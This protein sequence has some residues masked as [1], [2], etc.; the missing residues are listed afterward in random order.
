MKTTG[1]TKYL[2]VHIV[3]SKSFKIS[4]HQ[5]RRSFYR[6]ARQNCFW[7]GGFTSD[8]NQMYTNL[9]IRSRSLPVEENWF[10]FIGFCHKQILYET[11]QLKIHQSQ[12]KIYTFLEI[13]MKLF[14]T[15]NIDFVK[16][17][18]SYFCFELPSAIHD[19]RA[20]IFDLKYRNNSNLFYQMI[21]YLWILLYSTVVSLFSHCRCSL[22]MI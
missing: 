10:K 11:A 1:E 8:V 17:C 2:G 5:S 13:F 19:M 22:C 16:C 20:K 3:E 14:Q 7:K 18:Q 6:G 21:S 4:T 15:G 12:P 9:A